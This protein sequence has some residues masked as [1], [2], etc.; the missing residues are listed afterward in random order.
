MADDNSD[1]DD[2]EGGA[3][4][5]G[6][7][8]NI[9]GVWYPTQTI[10]WYHDDLTQGRNLYQNGLTVGKETSGQVSIALS[11]GQRPVVG[12]ASEVDL[13]D[14]QVFKVFPDVTGGHEGEI[15]V[16]DFD[17]NTLTQPVD[18][19]EA[20]VLYNQPID[21]E[22]PDYRGLLARTYGTLLLLDEDTPVDITSMTEPLL[23]TFD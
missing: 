9:G 20:T 16:K 21:E 7:R 22:D 23:T 19:N 17:G 2:S 14:L 13:L 4:T 12:T 8:V 1:W 6:A 11:F 5:L 3:R 10:I 15:I 18:Y